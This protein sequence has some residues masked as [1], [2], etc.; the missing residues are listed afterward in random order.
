MQ[1][2]LVDR[3]NFATP[4]MGCFCS[5]EG[6]FLKLAGLRYGFLMVNQ[7]TAKTMSCQQTLKIGQM[8]PRKEE[9]VQLTQD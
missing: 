9:T 4:Q 3:A 7:T 5:T 8:I 2:D 6:R 1:R